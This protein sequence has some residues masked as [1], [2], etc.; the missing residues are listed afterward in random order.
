MEPFPAAVRPRMYLLSCGRKDLH[1]AT[2]EMLYGRE[3]ETEIE[4]ERVVCLIM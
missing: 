2:R 3:I 4:T 1:S